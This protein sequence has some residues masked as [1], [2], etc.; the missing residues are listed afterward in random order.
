MNRLLACYRNVTSSLTDNHRAR[1]LLLISVAGLLASLLLTIKAWSTDRTYPLSPIIPG[2]EFPPLLHDGLF[3]IVLLALVSGVAILRLRTH[4]IS[5]ALLSLTGLVIVDI[6]RLQPWILHYGAILFLFS[7]CVPKKYIGAQ[8][9]L[10]AARIIIGGIYF[11][12]GLQKI[13]VRFFTDI[14]PWFTEHL[15]SPFHETGASVA[16]FIGLWVP[17]IEALFAIG[18]FTKRFRKVS[19]IGSTIMILLVLS[20]IGPTGQDWNSSVWP[21]NIAIYSTVL[22]LFLSWDA[23][24]SDFIKRQRNNALAWAAFF[25][26]WLVP[27]GNLIGVIDH[28]LSWSLY[29]GRVPEATLIGDETVLKTLSPWVEDEKLTFAHW[30]QTDINMVPYPEER[31]FREIFEKTCLQHPSLQ[32]KI[33]TPRLFVSNKHT[34]TLLSCHK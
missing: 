2:V 19:I 7:L 22:I 28:Y 12:S 10:D 34:E 5:L 4:L 1:W 25:I 14:F 30:T 3:I 11:W 29:S 27:A 18:F 26:F 9:L 13:N 15:W 16:L 31:V 24:F 21:W 33:I 6:T 32:L 23:T 8:S 17:I 20:S